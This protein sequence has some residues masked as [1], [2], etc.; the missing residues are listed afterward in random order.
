MA[1]FAVMS[2]AANAQNKNDG[3]YE[4]FIDVYLEWGGKSY[5]PNVYFDGRVSENIYD[6]NGEKLKFKGRSG[7]INYFTKLGW[8]FVEHINAPNG[9]EWLLLKK[10]VKNVQEAKEGLIFK[11][12]LKK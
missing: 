12:D 4:F 8:S 3:T 6:A 7:V 5:I 9:Y 2:L 10:Q 1:V 11:D